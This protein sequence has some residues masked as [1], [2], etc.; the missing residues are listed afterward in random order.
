M[1]RY[2]LTCENG[3]DFE[4]WFANNAAW[5]SQVAEGQLECPACGSIDIDKAPMAPN[6][7]KGKGKNDDLMERN[8]PFEAV[9]EMVRRVRSHVEKTAEYVGDRFPEEAR[10][11]HYE[12]DDKRGI[13]G[14]ASVEEADELREEGVEVYP[15][16]TLPEDQN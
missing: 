3:H 12:E 4:G 5:E 16:P 8:N 11:I 15:L 6:L 2:A 7:A 9:R 13:Y 1:I 14:Q 10:K